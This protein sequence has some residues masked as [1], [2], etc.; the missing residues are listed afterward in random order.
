MK[1]IAASNDVKKLG[2]RE[3][4]WGKQVRDEF[5]TQETRAALDT[6]TPSAYVN[7]VPGGTFERSFCVVL[8][9]LIWV[10]T[11]FVIVFAL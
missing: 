9:A 6:M 8:I 3:D 1:T 11:S 7:H 10:I 4:L 2:P 5:A